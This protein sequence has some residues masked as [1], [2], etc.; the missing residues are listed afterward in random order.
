LK[1]SQGVGIPPAVTAET[2]AHTAMS[3]P[4][5]NS[6]GKTASHLARQSNGVRAAFEAGSTTPVR[7]ELVEA[8]SA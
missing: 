5:P 6:G 4:R 3:M 7:V 8:F 1:V 2:I